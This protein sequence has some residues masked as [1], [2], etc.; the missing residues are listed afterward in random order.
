MAFFDEVG[1]KLSQVGQDAVQKTKDI[2]DIQKYN[3]AI[4][5]EE[6]VI[7]DLYCQLGKI[8]YETCEDRNNAYASYFQAID[9]S[10]VKIDDMTKMVQTLKSVVPCPKC[11]AEMKRE[12]IYCNICGAEMPKTQFNTVQ[13]VANRMCMNC[14][15]PI[16]DGVN[17]CML[18]G[19][20][21]QQVPVQP[22]A[23]VQPQEPAQPQVQTVV[24]CPV[25][26]ATCP[27]D[28]DFCVACGN[29]IEK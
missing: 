8:Y 22:Q 5:N 29:K 18:C 15:N 10:F 2:A 26:N 21:V 9:A 14:G 28:A 19:T 16:A 24:T 7:N 17:F 3:S 23:P 4:S 6:K 20:P 25:C 27:D 11:G 12:A 13:P 1:K